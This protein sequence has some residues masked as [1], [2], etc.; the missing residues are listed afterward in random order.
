MNEFPFSQNLFWDS[1]LAD[2]DL[3][4]NKQYIIERVITRGRLSDF[5]ILLTLY[6]REEVI[7]A[8]TKS[9]EMDTKTAHFCSWYFQI[10]QEKLHVSSFYR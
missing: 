10:P 7:R 1:S 9:K 8:I 5:N 4:K 3:R 2:I 6:P